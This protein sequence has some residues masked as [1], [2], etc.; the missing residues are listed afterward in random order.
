MIT[1]V[2]CP[3]GLAYDVF[4]N[5]SVSFDGLFI[6]FRYT[7]AAAKRSMCFIT[8]REKMG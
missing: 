5:L 8:I 6:I 1:H 7:H 3:I 4:R 2:T